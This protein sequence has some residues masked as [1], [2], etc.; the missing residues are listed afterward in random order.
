MDAEINAECNGLV[1]EVIA[2]GV[3]VVAL[4]EWC[5]RDGGGGGGGGGGEG[6]GGWCDMEA[7][8]RDRNEA[9]MEISPTFI[10][11]GPR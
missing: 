10:F 11:S 6:E 9:F 5:D 3:V 8:E 1:R 7:E 4:V 2:A